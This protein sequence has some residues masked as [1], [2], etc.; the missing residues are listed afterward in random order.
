V[1]QV[2]DKVMRGRAE[3]EKFTREIRLVDGKSPVRHCVMNQVIEVRGD[4]AASKCYL[5]TVMKR[6]D[7]SMI[8]VTAGVYSDTLVRTA[9]GWRFAERRLRGDLR[10]SKSK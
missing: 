1:F 9:A 8:T 5:L 6:K 10:W 3:L 2:D 7:G 4:R